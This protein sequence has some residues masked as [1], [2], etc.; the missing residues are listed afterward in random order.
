M[1]YCNF[2]INYPFLGG[3]LSNVSAYHKPNQ[4]PEPTFHPPVIE[5]ELIP[6]PENI[7]TAQAK[8]IIYNVTRSSILNNQTN[9]VG[10]VPSWNCYHSKLEESNDTSLSTVAF[11]P[12][13]IKMGF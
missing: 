13:L 8:E 10:R 12:I 6:T 1:L 11:T 2:S 9:T 3:N 7:T 5:K 4:R